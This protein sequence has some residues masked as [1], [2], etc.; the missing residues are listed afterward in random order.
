MATVSLVG[1]IVALIG[2]YS[3]SGWIAMGVA[4]LSFYWILNNRRQKFKINALLLFSFAITLIVI[5][6]TVGPYIITRLEDILS[7]LSLGSAQVRILLMEYAWKMIQSYPLWGVGLNHFTSALT[8]FDLPIGLKGFTYPVHNT[9][10]L[11]FS[12]LGIPAGLL[13][14]LFIY[15]I[16]QRS[17]KSLKD[18]W[19]NIGIW[20][21]TLTFLINGQFHTLFNQD[22]TFD[23]FMVLLG[24]LA[25]L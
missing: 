16:F 1:G 17:Y 13:F 8:T 2:T 15:L 22:P 18:N 4:A 21:G 23:V 24:Y 5:T 9:F 12:E 25:T 6:G 7:A 19:V 20:V 14:L 10:L 11:F 3:R